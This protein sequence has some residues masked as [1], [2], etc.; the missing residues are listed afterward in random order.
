MAESRRVKSRIILVR[1]GE[2]QYN[3]ESIFRGTLDVPLNETGLEQTRLTGLELSHTRISRIVSS[4]LARA[5]ATARA[6]AAQQTDAND[7]VIDPAFT[8][9]NF[10][11]WQGRSKDE[12]AKDY[13]EIYECWKTEPHL[14]Q[15]PGGETLEQASKRCSAGLDRLCREMPGKTFVIVTHRVIIKLLI[16]HMLGLPLS[17]FWRIHIDTCG[18]TTFDYL[19][20]SRQ[21]VLIQHNHNAHL[22]S[23]RSKMSTQDF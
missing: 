13:P 6:I 7:P 15:L 3:A 1:H 10:G 12:V 22:Y 23:L 14:A 20:D 17:D 2:T 5:L 4:P 21:F 8:D 16:L 11:E 18:I 9:L 19:H